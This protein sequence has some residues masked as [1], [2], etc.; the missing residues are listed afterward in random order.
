VLQAHVQVVVV[1]HL[2]EDAAEL[3]VRAADHLVHRPVGHPVEVDVLAKPAQQ[4]GQAG[5]P[6]TRC[7]GRQLVAIDA[8]QRVEAGHERLVDALAGEGKAEPQHA[9]GQR[10]V[11]DR[12]QQDVLERRDHHDL[13]AEPVVGADQFAQAVA[14]PLF[15][16]PFVGE[17]H[18]EVGAGVPAL[19]AKLPRAAGNQLEEALRAGRAEVDA[20]VDVHGPCAGDPAGGLREVVIVAGIEQ[21]LKVVPDLLPGERV[22][23]LQGLQRGEDASGGVPRRAP[24]RLALAAGQAAGRVTQAIPEVGALPG[25]A[26]DVGGAEVDNPREGRGGLGGARHRETAAAREARGTA[27]GCADAGEGPATTLCPSFPRGRAHL[28][29]RIESRRSTAPSRGCGAGCNSNSTECG[30]SDLCV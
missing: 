28:N 11:R 9:G 20:A 22:V 25:E 17:Q 23:A 13:V 12:R 27:R 30:L 5:G 6:P 26:V 18:F 14:K 29:L 3:P 1:L 7:Q 10:R 19:G 24:L 4:F 2:E 8:E 15:V 16:F 21:V